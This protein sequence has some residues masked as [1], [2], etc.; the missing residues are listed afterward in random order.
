VDE[1]LESPS[2]TVYAT[3]SYQYDTLDDLTSV[4][5]G[6][7]PQRTFVYDSLKR[8]IQTRGKLDEGSGMKY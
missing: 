7:Q 5:Q 3:T 8:L 1:M 2:N 4:T 6:T